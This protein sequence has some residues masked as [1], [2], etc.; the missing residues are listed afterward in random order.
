MVGCRLC[1][2]KQS[3]PIDWNGLSVWE[4]SIN[5]IDFGRTIPGTSMQ[6][7]ES[8]LPLKMRRH[9]KRHPSKLGSCDPSILKGWSLVAPDSISL[10]LWFGH[11]HGFSFKWSW[12]LVHGPHSLRNITSILKLSVYNHVPRV[13][14]F[15]AFSYMGC[16]CFLHREDKE[17]LVDDDGVIRS[18]EN[19]RQLQNV[20]WV[21]L[22]LGGN[23]PWEAT[24]RGGRMNFEFKQMEGKKQGV[25][26]WSWH[27]F[28]VNWLSQSGCY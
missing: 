14:G 27:V 2:P 25:G 15:D 19:L 3:A 23:V 9:G 8:W 22:S 6:K 18:V 1:I 28:K 10:K 5:L 16:F 13:V 17:Y 7:L 21:V 26:E 12:L 4:V 20:K 11:V 24:R